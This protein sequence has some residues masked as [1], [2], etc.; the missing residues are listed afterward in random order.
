MPN[1]YDVDRSIVNFDVAY[2]V[3]MT[4][5]VSAAYRLL[6]EWVSRARPLALG[7]QRMRML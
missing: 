1:R 7:V 2:H 3:A 4:R 5:T 6:D